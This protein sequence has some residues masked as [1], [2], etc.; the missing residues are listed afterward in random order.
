MPNAVSPFTLDR[1]E[2]EQPFFE[3]PG[4][5]YGRAHIDKTFG[6]DLEARSFVEMLS[7]QSDGGGAGYVAVERIEGMLHGRAGSFALLHL[8]TMTHDDQSMQLPIVPGSGT[9]ELTGISGEARIEIAEDGA[10]TLF[11]DYEVG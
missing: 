7:V 1:F 4:I 10:H 2:P 8:G 5:R 11:V 3:E 9:G 6:G